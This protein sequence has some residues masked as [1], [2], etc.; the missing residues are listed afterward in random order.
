RPGVRQA[1]G[2]PIG[3]DRRGHPGAAGAATG[4]RRAARRRPGRHPR[5][6][7]RARVRRPGP[8]RGHGPAGPGPGCRAGP[9][10]RRRP[11]VFLRV[12]GHSAGNLV[13][14]SHTE[15]MTWGI[16]GPT[17]LVGYA[18]LGIVILAAVM[19]WRRQQTA[20]PTGPLR[21]LTPTEVALLNGGRQLA[22]YS[23]LAALR[24]AGAVQTASGYP[25]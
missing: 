1:L 21:G 18:A 12:L 9:G 22:V 8:A 14:P 10:G 7:P 5:P 16:S 13:T 19:I 24:A 6:V 11:Q 2:R 4:R 25:M 17:F 15:R 3:G 20:G 23:S